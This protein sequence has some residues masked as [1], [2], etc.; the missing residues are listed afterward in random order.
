MESPPER[1]GM[2][3]DHT[4]LSAEALDGLIEE[5]A[6]RYHGL[7]ETE[8]PLEDHKAFVEKAL[9]D[10]HLMVWYD[11]ETQS[12]ALCEVQSRVGI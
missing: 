11:G 2:A 8:S 5:Y 1:G 10:G 4:K 3:I 6:T 12:A 9:R 7:N